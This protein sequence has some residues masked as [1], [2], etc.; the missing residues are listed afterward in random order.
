MTRFK[1]FTAFLAAIVMSVSAM[2]LTAGATQTHNW[3]L[4][5]IPNSS[6]TNKSQDKRTFVATYDTVRAYDQ[7]SNFSS[8]TDDNGRIAKVEL[9]GKIT[10]DG[11]EDAVA[12]MKSTTGQTTMYY[13]GTHTY[14]TLYFYKNGVKYV[15]N[16]GEEIHMIHTLKQPGLGPVQCNMTGTSQADF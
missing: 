6:G 13:E 7:C 10:R 8:S 11:S 9:T 4:R 2:S 1:K 3:S 16:T 14:S 12:V 5:Y 15:I